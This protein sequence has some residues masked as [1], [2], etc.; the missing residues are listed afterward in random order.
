M[1]RSLTPTGECSCA[2]IR[3]RD[4]KSEFVRCICLADAET[5]FVGT[6]HGS[7]HR[8]RLPSGKRE[9]T[10]IQL[11]L[12]ENQMDYIGTFVCGHQLWVR[13]LGSCHQLGTFCNVLTA[14]RALSCSRNM[15]ISFCEYHS[16]YLNC[17]V[18]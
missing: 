12:A 8:A 5:L 3:H 14:L 7:V 13:A 4:S 1:L 15:T 17:R 6:N 18:Q 16:S 2:G 10:H 9:L 11:H